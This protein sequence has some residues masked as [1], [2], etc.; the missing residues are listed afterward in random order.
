MNY[1]SSIVKGMVTWN[2][3]KTLQLGMWVIFWLISH[4]VTL[5][6]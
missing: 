5:T 1:S 4:W 2:E 3:I 6:L